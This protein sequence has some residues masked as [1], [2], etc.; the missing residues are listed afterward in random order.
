MEKD[1]RSVG[2]LPR[3]VN[4]KNRI[5]E[6]QGSQRTKLGGRFSVSKLSFGEERYFRGGNLN[7]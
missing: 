1:G 3:F 7:D 2:P 6:T 5:E 4:G